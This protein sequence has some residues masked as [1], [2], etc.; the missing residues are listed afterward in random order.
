L[1]IWPSSWC[2]PLDRALAVKDMDADQ[3]LNKFSPL[4]PLFGASSN[5]GSR[6]MYPGWNW[7]GALSPPTATFS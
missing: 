3:V 6:Y 2:E 7:H 4:L 1:E 5:T